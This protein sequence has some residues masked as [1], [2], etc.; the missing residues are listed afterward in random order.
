VLD[1]FPR[2][3]ERLNHGGY[4]SAV[5][6]ANA[7]HRALMTNPDVLILDE[8][9]KAWLTSGEIWRIC[10]PGVVLQHQ[11]VIVD[12]KNQHRHPNHRP[13]T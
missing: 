10:A 11:Q 3:K 5:L 13:A 6:A 12:K 2:L 7:D 8:V 1:T 4:S 9:P